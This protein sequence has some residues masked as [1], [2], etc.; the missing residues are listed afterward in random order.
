MVVVVVVTVVVAATALLLVGSSGHNVFQRC[1]RR[2]GM[3][4]PWSRLAAS[5]FVLGMGQRSPQQARDTGP[6]QE[7]MGR[8][9]LGVWCRH[10]VT[11]ISKL[12]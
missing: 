11:P 2:K 12:G 4:V 5:E 10:R 3:C 7:H 9:R 1:Q 8:L 6:R